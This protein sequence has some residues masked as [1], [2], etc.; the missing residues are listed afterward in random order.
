MSNNINLA[1]IDKITSI[2]LS[3]DQLDTVI[4]IASMFHD[5]WRVYWGKCNGLSKYTDTP[6]YVTNATNIKIN[7]NVPYHDLPR[8]FTDINYNLIM[9]ALKMLNNNINDPQLCYNLI[10][11]YRRII[12][13]SERGGPKDVNFKMLPEKEKEKCIDIFNVCY[14]FNTQRT[15]RFMD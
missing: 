6:Y 12:N 7:V 2:K 10:N 11:E 9:F 3:Y 4:K 8:E 13:T 5:V 14:A 15:I 1:L